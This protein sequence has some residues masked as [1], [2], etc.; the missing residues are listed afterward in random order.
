MV[1]C[2]WLIL[3]GCLF[4]QFSVSGKPSKTE[5]VDGVAA[6]VENSIILKSDVMQQAFIFAQQ[7]G[8]DPAKNP[9]FLRAF[10]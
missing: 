1:K 7:Q 6:V 10:I 8:V 4:A 5:T 2:V 3:C 9:S